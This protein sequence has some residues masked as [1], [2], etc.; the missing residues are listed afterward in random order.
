MFLL[1]ASFQVLADL[2]YSETERC[3]DT[4][5]LTAILEEEINQSQDI[6]RYHA[7]NHILELQN[8]DS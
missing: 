3:L 4:R 7:I 2:G 6:I 5:H 1:V 8:T